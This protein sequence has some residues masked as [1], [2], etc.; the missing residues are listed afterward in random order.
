[1][2]SVRSVVDLHPFYA[3][4][5]PRRAMPAKRPVLTPMPAALLVVGE[6][7]VCEADGLRSDAPELP[8]VVVVAMV[9]ERR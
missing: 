2:Q 7:S 4:N 1:M 5:A 3:R 9:L 6:V 8:L